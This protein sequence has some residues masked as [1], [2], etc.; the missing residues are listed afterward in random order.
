MLVI[1]NSEVQ[2]IKARR[3][4][5]GDIVKLNAGDKVPTDGLIIAS[6]DLSCNES[7]LTG[8]PED[9][10]KST[11]SDPFLLSG[12]TVSTGY[13]E[14]LVTAVGASSRW[15]KTKAALA[16]ES[17][18][19]PL[20]E[21]LD[22]LASQIG[23]GGLVAAVATF[24][25][26]MVQWV[27]FPENRPVGMTVLKYVIRA[28]IMAVTIV[29]VAV[30]EGLPLAVTISLAFSTQKM[31]ADNNL[32][33][34]LAACETMGNATNICSDKTGTLT[35]NLMTCTHVWVAEDLHEGEIDEMSLPSAAVSNLIS[36]ITLNSTAE[37]SNKSNSKTEVEVL[38]NKTEGALLM[39]AK[40]K[41]GADYQTIRETNFQP[42]RGDKIIP[43]NS[44]RKCM[45][46]LLF[47][48]V[49]D[50]GKGASSYG[51]VSK[52]RRSA[53]KVNACHVFCKGAPEVVLSKCTT[54]TA[55]NGD[56]KPLT[57]IVKREIES[58]L[59]KMTTQ[60]L[61][62]VALAHSPSVSAADASNNELDLIETNL[63]LDAICG[64]QD[65]IRPDVPKA[66]QA[67]QRAGIIVRMV[68]GDNIDTARA[69]ATECGILTPDG[70]SMEGPAFR[71]LTP[72]QL[73]EILPK[74]QVVFHFLFLRFNFII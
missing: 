18:E 26:L 45:T 53:D 38:G 46:T 14:M 52:G 4:L 69:I 47:T 72:K 21:K 3:L 43:F 6:S 50:V 13:C 16:V 17:E 73:D 70:L 12:T 31:M 23:V 39:M 40:Y 41:F 62:T 74:L 2:L 32:I 68:T 59:K 19:T 36:G 34:V 44:D 25:V 1:R 58:V 57:A 11:D 54:Y 37:L 10:L 67:C 7:A 15:G 33:R 30:P 35:Q 48:N 24:A 9:V 51:V 20:Q 55:R 71:K 42:F 64:I 60:S 65:P 8:E 61:R 56:K 27:C 29:V 28:A 5:V 49:I 66:V 22:T 63:N